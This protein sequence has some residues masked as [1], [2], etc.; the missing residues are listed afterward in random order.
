M[1]V[2]NKL[3]PVRILKIWFGIL[4]VLGG[5][6]TLIF[7][8]WLAFSPFLMAKGDMPADATVR[9]VV[10]ERSWIP[11]HELELTPTEDS[12][13]FW[14]E[15]ARLVKAGGE[16]RFVTTNWWLHFLSLGEIMLG[17][18]I[19]LYVI[20]NL[21]RLLINVLDDRPFAAANGRTLRQSGYILLIMAALW[22]V[23]DF[24]L[25]SYVLSRIDVTNIHL[26]PAITLDKD[27]FVV[28]LLFLVF[29]IILTRG[30]ELQEHEQELEEEQA[31]TI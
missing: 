31:Y 26:R 24:A 15:E 3:W 25:S 14:M 20:W 11:V 21:R 29:G 27:A 28:G 4:V 18:V 6:G 22:P 7:L 8:V 17:A 2:K 10:G 19:I 5:A 23:A 13:D 12:G 9:V 1:S 16:L 30:H